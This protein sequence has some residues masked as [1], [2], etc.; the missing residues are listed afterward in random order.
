MNWQDAILANFTTKS[1]PMLLVIDPDN[2]LR[3][4][5]LLAEIQNR[6]FD[7]LELQEEVE[8]RN[9][10]ERDY[11]VR[12]DDGEARHVV[13]VVHTTDS[14][15]YIPY[16]L[17]KKSKRIELGVA[18]LFPQLNAI[19]VHGLDNA[20]YADLY[21]AHQEL[22]ARNEFLRGERQT[23]EFIL[24]FVFDLDP[25]VAGDIN[26]WVEFLIHKHYN[27]RELPAA[28]EAYVLDKLLPKAIDRGLRPEF[29]N[30]STA[31]YGW[32]G[33]CWIR[34]VKGIR[35]GEVEEGK[36]DLINFADPRLR[37]MMGHLFAECLL[38][39]FDISIEE[40][41]EEQQ[42]LAI[43]LTTQSGKPD[44]VGEPRTNQALYN[45]KA[46]LSRLA[47]MDEAT[48]PTGKTDLR[49]WLNLAAEWAEVIYLTNTLPVE[50]YDKVAGDLA[51]ARQTLDG[52]F[53]S[54]I[55]ERYSAV[56]HYQDNKGPILLST[57]NRWLY[58]NLQT[59]ERV[60]LVCFDGMALDQWYLLRDYLDSK[61]HDLKF[62]E[63]RAYAMAPT[64]TPISRQA[65]FAGRPPVAF[66]ET[67]DHTD[68]DASR[69]Y[70]YWV[71][72]NVPPKQID[73]AIVKLNDPELASIKT[74]VDGKIIRL[75]ILTNLFDNVMHA[76]KGMP[77]LV[78]KRVYYDTLCSQLENGF[79]DRLFNLLLERHYRV[80]VTSD[81]G[82]IAGEGIGLT[83]P[84]ALIESYAKRVAVFDQ[85]KFA[86]EYAEAHHMRDFRTKALPPG[87]HPVY[88]PG[89]QLFAPLG[90][91]QISHGGL[92]LEEL[93]VP[94]VE[95]SRS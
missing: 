52:Y 22:L 2:L 11:R 18:E 8:F 43:G 56:D 34:Y 92:T 37:S 71:N 55:Q 13:V 78:D 85:E 48:L 90:G 83:P 53:W 12:W 77:I 33:E 65:L 66:A 14:R 36:Q 39:R 72:H 45:L 27:A 9:R 26:R 93:V 6:N 10:F 29:L 95:V 61:L 7:V 59:R 68:K 20:Y 73:Y 41:P 64:I 63:N 81:H 50:L 80:Y 28:L 21:P 49:D 76:T 82:N 38:P 24:R 94:F 58:Q 42:W 75:G 91:T 57:V 62:K 84:K 79:V 40:L 67:I 54:F 86:Q 74:I 31:F 35:G 4:D 3:D 51:T 88:P 17:W 87:I 1:E 15:R 60:A 46:R 70:A 19:V 44:K 47:N 5:A 25:L 89:N 23:I 16:D 30:D 32:L 69:W